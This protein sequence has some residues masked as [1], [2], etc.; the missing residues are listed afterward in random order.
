M[1]YPYPDT[2]EVKEKRRNIEL[3]RLQPRSEW[4][5]VQTAMTQQTQYNEISPEVTMKFNLSVSNRSK[6]NQNTINELK[7]APQS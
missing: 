3:Y 6:T 7:Y 1:A 4:D 5:A 2:P